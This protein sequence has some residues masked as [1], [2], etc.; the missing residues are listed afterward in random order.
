M[1]NAAYRKRAKLIIDRLFAESRTQDERLE[2]LW[3]CVLSRP[4]S[5]S[6]RQDAITFL[7]ETQSLETPNKERISEPVA[8]QELCHSLLSSNHFVFRL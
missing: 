4:M 3:L 5:P 8:W 7:E 2:Q 6:E 1:N